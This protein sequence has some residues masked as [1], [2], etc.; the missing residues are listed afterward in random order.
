MRTNKWAVAALAI[1]S[2][3]A[4]ANTA[5]AEVS[6]PAPTDIASIESSEN[7]DYAV[8]FFADDLN[9][10]A[11]GASGLIIPVRNHRMRRTLLKPRTSFVR[12]LLQSVENL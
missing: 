12:P 5:S 11:Y 10:S 4:V 6:N 8:E 3:I 9:G 2:V 7:G 1:A